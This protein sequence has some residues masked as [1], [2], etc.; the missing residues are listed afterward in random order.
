[1]KF[2]FR[3]FSLIS[4][5]GFVLMLAGALVSGDHSQWNVSMGI[6]LIMLVGG[7]CIA[8]A[9]A[10][11]RAES[12]KIEQRDRMQLERIA[13]RRS[14]E[15][16]KLLD[17][18]EIHR[19]AL[20]RNFERSV[21]KNDYGAIIRDTRS[22]VLQDFMSSVDINSSIVSVNEA[23]QLV[24]ARLD[25]YAQEDKERGFSVE[26]LPAD[27]R[28]FE[29]WVAERLRGFG[30]MAEPTR[31]SGDQGVD[32]IAIVNG[33]RLGIQCKLYS[34][35]VGNKAV[36]EVYA[37]KSYHKLDVVAVLSNADFTSSARD[38]AESTG[39][40]LLSHHDIPQIDKK[41]ERKEL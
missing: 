40:F 1:M 16:E 23:A 32:V 31:Q 12:K 27:G 2:F 6:G 9:W 10:S 20:A 14:L 18:I 5:L 29:Y 4:G 22:Q 35:P 15:L 21:V 24:S 19:S 11:H 30:W 26:D 28:D 34:N 25:Y 17:A 37:G 3:C 38:L 36:Q 8:L 7:P 39:V 33:I 41:I 13:R